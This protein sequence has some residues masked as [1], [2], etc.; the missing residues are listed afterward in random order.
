[1]GVLAQFDR[2]VEIQVRGL[3]PLHSHLDMS[4]Q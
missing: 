3:N 2:A 4:L 1:M